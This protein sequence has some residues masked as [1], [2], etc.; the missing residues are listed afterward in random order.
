LLQTQ[1][2]LLQYNLK[3]NQWSF[4]PEVSLFGNYNL[5]YLNNNFSKI[6]NKSFPNSYAGLL[7]SIPIFQG[8]KR[9]QEVRQAKFQL[10]RVDNTILNLV[11][12]INSQYVQ[13]LAAYKSNLY[14]YISQQ[15]N[16]AL[17][18]EVYDIIQLQYRS[19]IKTYLEVINSETDLRTAQINFYNALYQVLS[20]KIEVQQSL[21]II[22]Y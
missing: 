11:N 15:E 16:V 12:N 5:N 9:V 1:K 13:A 14:N 10:L 21:G 2:N 17:A 19:G 20:S 8:G 3:Y 4:L 22:S 18:K 6:Y 7:L